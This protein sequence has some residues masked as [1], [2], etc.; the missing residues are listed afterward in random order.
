MLGG[1]PGGNER[2]E[3]GNPNPQ[4]PQQPQQQEAPGVGTLLKGL[5]GR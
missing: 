3:R 1:M 4:Q 5:F 2:G